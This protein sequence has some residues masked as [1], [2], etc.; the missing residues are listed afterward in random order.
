MRELDVLLER[1]L[2]E[3]YPSAPASEQAAFETLLE[4]P[5]PE[6]F[7]YLMGRAAPGRPEWVDVIAKLA[8]VGH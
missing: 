1:Y 7:A 2:E 4:L 5:D 6:L 8:N 3:R